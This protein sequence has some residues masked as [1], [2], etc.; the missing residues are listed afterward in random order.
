MALTHR[1]V[2]LYYP[3]II[4]YIRVI[5]S[6]ISILVGKTQCW[7]F[8]VFYFTSFAFDALDGKVARMYD[9]CSDFGSVL[10]MVTD[11]CSTS[12]LLVL[13]A[14]LYP[15]HFHFAALALALD[16]SSHWFHM[17]SAIKSGAHHKSNEAQSNIIMRLYYGNF[18]FFGYLCVGAEVFYLAVYLLAFVKTN[19][20]SAGVGGFG[21]VIVVYLVRTIAALCAP[22]YFLKQFV[23]VVQLLAA[24]DKCVERDVAAKRA[25]TIVNAA[26]GK[27]KL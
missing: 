16:I 2:Y 6:I 17:Y 22:G 25:S 23:N 20:T 8:L 12:M 18:N 3:N 13:L 24:A 10:D 21:G 9:Q 15:D 7:T 14:T 1:D 11:R 5:C 4:G 19:N 26:A 27:R